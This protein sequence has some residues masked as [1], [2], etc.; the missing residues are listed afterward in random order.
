VKTRRSDDFAPVL[1]NVDRRKQRQIA[2]TGR[3][4]KRIFRVFEMPHRYDVVSVLAP[5]RGRAEISLIKGF[6]NDE[7]LR[8]KGVWPDRT[9]D[10]EP[11]LSRTGGSM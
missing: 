2:R 4:Y 7:H 10:V 1:K 9:W 6:W 3:V 11:A 8:R 5:V